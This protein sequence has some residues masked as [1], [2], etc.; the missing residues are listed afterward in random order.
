[1]S[2]DYTKGRGVYTDPIELK[3]I[4]IPHDIFFKLN[5]DFSFVSQSVR[6]MALG[7]YFN[8]YFTNC[9]YEG[10]KVSNPEAYFICSALDAETKVLQ[11][12]A[13]WRCFDEFYKGRNDIDYELAWDMHIKEK[14]EKRK[15]TNKEYYQKRKQAQGNIEERLQ[16]ES[17]EGQE[18]L[19]DAL[20]KYVYKEISTEE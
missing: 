10:L 16:K 6:W 13:R 20:N 2:K 5:H 11:N 19:Q 9:G 1:M 17:K 15:E 12:G 18:N 14:Q 8:H 7:Y 3:Y 4:Q